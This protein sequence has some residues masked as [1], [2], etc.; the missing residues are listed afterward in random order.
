MTRRAS[1]G[2]PP[3]PESARS[4]VHARANGASCARSPPDRDPFAPRSF[5]DDAGMMRVAQ[6][7]GQ[8]KSSTHYDPRGVGRDRSQDDGDEIGV[9]ERLEWRRT[10]ATREKSGGSE[11]A[12]EPRRAGFSSSWGRAPTAER[13][14]TG[15]GL[16]QDCGGAQLGWGGS[17]RRSRDV[18]TGS[19]RAS[20]K[21]RQ[22]DLGADRRQRSPLTSAG[23]GRRCT[24]RRAGIAPARWRP[25]RDDRPSGNRN[26]ALVT[27]RRRRRRT[28]GPG[29]HA[30]CSF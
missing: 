11:R 5:G 14:R 7:V 1:D 10:Q 22:G 28:S 25:G 12:K 18:V 27:D 30:A 21:R 3:P 17:R 13:T 16:D 6:R 29:W 20:G 4:P 2:D 23:T 9:T 19:E 24:G 26:A 8:R 15:A